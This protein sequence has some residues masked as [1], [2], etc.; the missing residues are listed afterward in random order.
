MMGRAVLAALC[1]TLLGGC[2][3]TNFNQARTPCLDNTGGWCTFTTELAKDAWQYAQYAEN[4]YD[5][6]ED[7]YFTLPSGVTVRRPEVKYSSGMSYAIFE[8]KDGE[9]FVETVIAFRG[10]EFSHVNDWFYGNIG[11]TQRREALDLY[12]TV[13]R[14]LVEQGWSDPRIIVTGHSLGGALAMEVA[15]RRNVRAFVFNASPRFT[16]QEATGE[17]RRVAIG[18]RGEILRGLRRF[19]QMPIHDGMVINCNAGVRP[20]NDH[21]MRALAECLTWIAAFEDEVAYASYELNDIKPP[22]VNAYCLLDENGEIKE[23]LGHPGVMTRF[24][25]GFVGCDS[26]KAPPSP[27]S[28]GKAAPGALPVQ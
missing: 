18:E 4:A 3:A 21:Y 27:A 23:R 8:R 6:D 20:A 11:D 5:R 17:A 15:I 16:R 9:E 13:K 2:L 25:D 24:E 22:R 1:S 28:R 14:E 26:L 7:R 10:T 19:R 12:D